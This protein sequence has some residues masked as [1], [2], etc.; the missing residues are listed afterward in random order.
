MNPTR[1]RPV[2]STP[3]RPAGLEFHV[4]RRSET[5]YMAGQYNVENPVRVKQSACKRANDA[6]RPRPL[7]TG[8]QR[9]DHSGIKVLRHVPAVLLLE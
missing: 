8:L 6:S 5:G 3:A 7:F 9:S 2:C 4:R 1:K